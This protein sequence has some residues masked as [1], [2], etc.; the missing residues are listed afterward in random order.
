MSESTDRNL[1]CGII[2]LNNG[3]VQREQL[4]TATRRSVELKRPMSQCLRDIEAISEEQHLLLEALVDQQLKKNEGD[5]Q[6][7]LRQLSSIG[8]ALEDLQTIDG[9]DLQKSLIAIGQASHSEGAATQPA[10]SHDVRFRKLRPHAK[11]GLG[12][13]FI[14]TDTELGREVALKE[15]QDRAARSSEAIA[16]FVKEAEVTGK[17]EHP[18]IVP[19]YGL[20]H[21]ADGR[22][23]YAMKFIQGDSLQEAIRQFHAER[24]DDHARNLKLRTLLQRFIDVCHAIHFAHS[25]GVLHRDLKPGNIMIGKYGETL[26]VDWGLAKLLGESE[27]LSTKEIPAVQS[28]SQHHPTQTGVTIGTPNFM[29]PEQ[30]AG[31]IEKLDATSDVYSLGATLYVLLTGDAPFQ[32]GDLGVMLQQVQRGK[33]S[34]PRKKDQRIPQPLEAICLQAMQREQTAR[35]ATAEELARDIEKWLAD[36]PVSAYREPIVMQARRWMRKHQTATVSTLVLLLT[37][38]IALGIGFGAVQSEQEKTKQALAD[39]LDAKEEAT[40]QQKLAETAEGRAKRERALAIEARDAEALQRDRAESEKWEADRL[41]YASRIKTADAAWRLGNRKLAWRNLEDAQWDLRGWEHDYL[42]SKFLHGRGRLR[43]H[44]GEIGA[45]AIHPNGTHVVSSRGGFMSFNQAIVWTLTQVSTVPYGYET[46]VISPVSLAAPLPI[47][48]DDPESLRIIREATSPNV[49]DVAYSPDGE[50]IVMGIQDGSVRIYDATTGKNVSIREGHNAGVNVVRYCNNGDWIVSASRDATLKVWDAEK[51]EELRT[52][53]GHVGPVQSMEVAEDGS[54]AVSCSGASVIVWDL[55]EGKALTSL[56]DNSDLEV[57]CVAF[58]QDGASI[59]CG[60]VGGSMEIWNLETGE[61]NR[62]LLGHAGSVNDVACFPDGLRIISASDDKTARIWELSTGRILK[63]ISGHD[64]PLSSVAIGREGKL[65]VSGG[66]DGEVHL[67]EL[68]RLDQ[69]H[70][71]LADVD[72][73]FLKPNGMLLGESG[74]LVWPVETEVISKDEQELRKLLE[75]GHADTIDRV[76]F[77]AAGSLLASCR[78]NVIKVWDAETNELLHTFSEQAERIV[79]L[80]FMPDREAILTQDSEGVVR[81]RDPAS[82]ELLFEAS[83]HKFASRGLAVSP[84]GKWVATSGNEG[85]STE[86]FWGY[87]I[88]IRDTRTGEIVHRLPA[89]THSIDDLAFSADGELLASAST[90]KSAK[91][92]DVATGRLLKTLSGHAEGVTAVGFHPAGKR[93]VTSGF[94]QTLK[95]WDVA[96]GRE[97]VTLDGFGDEYVADFKFSLDGRRLLGRTQ[98]KTLLWSANLASETKELHAHHGLIKLITFSPNGELLASAGADNV[99]KI[100]H[101]R[102]GREVASFTGIPG[103][104]QTLDFTPNNSGIL[105]GSSLKKFSE[106]SVV[107]RDITTG[108]TTL[109]LDD[110]ILFR[111][112]VRVSDDGNWIAFSRTDE[113]IVIMDLKTQTRLHEIDGHEGTVTGLWFSPTKDRLASISLDHKLRIWNIEKGEQLLEVDCPRPVAARFSDDGERIAY[114]NVDRTVTSWNAT[115]GKRIPTDPQDETELLGNLEHPGP[116]QVQYEGQKVWLIERETGKTLFHAVGDS[117]IT[118]AKIS[119][120]GRQMAIGGT[121]G[122][123]MLWHQPGRILDQLRSQSAGE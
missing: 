27:D 122:T 73:R 26:V 47:V 50:R 35:Y 75:S 81:I 12:E 68:A 9:S 104:I 119:P 70:Q 87:A 33:F 48:P 3:F 76:C 13:V 23:F 86:G 54:K 72:Y 51:G 79:A 114:I 34:P 15:I 69:A 58:T 5:T 63:S 64:G 46:H 16:R 40:R 96:S 52:L 123:I 38:A 84:D 93:L 71:V 78:I 111:N 31:E 4:L 106:G 115:T 89:H 44:N 10:F 121:N 91:I 94:D 57:N 61:L 24:L 108:M 88:L 20:G 45:V 14:A 60:C 7:S 56:R 85:L 67:W 25:R 102:T 116:I 53:E 29:P 120:D 77:N 37:T 17:L 22:P 107:G 43:G 2:A 99:V 59:V 11:G 113:T 49:L 32:G 100:W 92:W 42:Y 109:Q 41:L 90:D 8:S 30:A 66:A 65:V 39:A 1:L 103:S 118:E 18:N 83:G 82:G 21:Y 62:T 74:N 6:K 112:S 19:V 110:C 55:D 95:V 101:C 105:I 28:G 117:S 36:E 97:L 80:E 98:N